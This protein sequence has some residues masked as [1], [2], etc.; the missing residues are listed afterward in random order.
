MQAALAAVST[1]IQYIISSMVS[2][3][4]TCAIDAYLKDH[5]FSGQVTQVSS[6]CPGIFCVTDWVGPR[7]ECAFC[8]NF[9]PGYYTKSKAAVRLHASQCC[10]PALGQ[11]VVAT[12]WLPSAT[13]QFGTICDLHTE[14]EMRIS[15]LPETTLEEQLLKFVRLAARP[16]WLLCQD[17]ETCQL[18]RTRWLLEHDVDCLPSWLLLVDTLALCKSILPPALATFAVCLPAV[19]TCLTSNRKLL[20]AFSASTMRLTVLT[21]LGAM[22]LWGHSFLCEQ[23]CVLSESVLPSL[24][25]LIGH[26]MP[27]AALLLQ[28]VVWL[29][30]LRLHFEEATCLYSVGVVVPEPEPEPEPRQEEKEGEEEQEEEEE[31]EEEGEDTAAPASSRENKQRSTGRSELS[32]AMYEALCRVGGMGTSSWGASERT[33]YTLTSV[34]RFRRSLH[35]SSEGV[36]GQP[37]GDGVLASRLSWPYLLNAGVYLYQVAWNAAS[38]GDPA[39][40][41]KMQSKWTQLPHMVRLSFTYTNT[42]LTRNPTLPFCSSFV[43]CGKKLMRG[44]VVEV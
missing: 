32:A 6:D 38:V 30:L 15:F 33:A 19:H 34:G 2:L 17:F 22:H 24:A 35:P 8:F 25:E 3:Q 36:P 9:N 5:Y 1:L 31:S 11:P 26:Q 23:W 7:W 13:S 43:L 4:T 29:H 42:P 20:R 27:G 12:L 10:P 18:I 14:M 37:P 21:L 16:L 44:N 28:P 39:G 40:S 41:K